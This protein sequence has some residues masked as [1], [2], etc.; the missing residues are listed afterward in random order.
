MRRAED[1][2]I[3]CTCLLIEREIF[4]IKVTWNAQKRGIGEFEG[5][6]GLSM[7][8]M[9]VL[10]IDGRTSGGIAYRQISLAREHQWEQN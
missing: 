9:I 2:Y 4:K 10:I 8:E 1:S 3:E 5:A 6:V 7:D